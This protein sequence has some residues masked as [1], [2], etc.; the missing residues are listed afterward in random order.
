MLGAQT[1][2]VP[3]VEPLEEWSYVCKGNGEVAVKSRMGVVD[4][5][6][7]NVELVAPP[8]FMEIFANNQTAQ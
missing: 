7:E 1:F 6:L 8:T 3:S 5:A 2:A 4:W